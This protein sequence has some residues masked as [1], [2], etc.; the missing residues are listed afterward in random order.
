M[1]WNRE[2]VRRGEQCRAINLSL[3][4]FLEVLSINDDFVC[5]GARGGR[6]YGSTSHL[7]GKTTPRGDTIRE[8]NISS[9]SLE[10]KKKWSNERGSGRKAQSLRTVC[11]N[12]NAQE[13]IRGVLAGK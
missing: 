7:A 9:L 10:R 2:G 5:E 8:T 11:L 6:I 3:V 13:G 12:H 4:I 1:N